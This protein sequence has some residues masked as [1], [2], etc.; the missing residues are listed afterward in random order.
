M[1]K[2]ASKESIDVLGINDFNTFDGYSEFEQYS[3]EKGVYP[4]FNVEFRCITGNT[5]S[6]PCRWNDPFDFDIIYLCGKGLKSQVKLSID[7]TNRIKSLW[8]GTQ[9]HIWK[10]LSK[11][12]SYLDDVNLDVTLDYCEIRSTYSKGTL[13]ERH[14]AKA[15]YHKFIAKWQEKTDLSRAFN[16]LFKSE[17]NIKDPYDENRMQD[18]ILTRLFKSDKPAF[19][20]HT[21]DTAIQMEDARDIILQAGGIPCY[22]LLGDA[23]KGLTEKEASV[24]KLITELKKVN[25]HAVE[26]ISNRCSI[27]YIKE[28]TYRFKE[29]GFC[30]T[31][32]TEHNQPE[33][34]P[35]LPTT[36]GNVPFDSELLKT[37]H[38]GA[39]IIA[40]HQELNRANRIGFVESCGKRSDLKLSDLVQKGQSAIQ[41]RINVPV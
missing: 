29:K 2:K 32:G 11:L 25:I 26:F 13:R 30:V 28:T 24:D 3:K 40:A 38:E 7:S 41:K 14:L 19:V 37:A 36:R 15:L 1:V 18:E 33:M 23:L 12:N 35:L 10:I 34:L 8:K 21:V 31:F 27:E 9:D 17:L 39:C 5:E 6:Q 20:K 4:L 22:P 16:K